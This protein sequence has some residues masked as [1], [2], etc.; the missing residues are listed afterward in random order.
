MEILKI[1]ITALTS[2]GF[3]AFIEFLIRRK[4]D[5][6]QRLEKIEKSLEKTERDNCRTQML[7]LINHYPQAH[8]EIMKIA[9]HYF[10]DLAG[11]WYMTSIFNKWLISQNLGKPE[12]FNSD[13]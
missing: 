2:S 4:D 10:R 3:F 7:I 1:V 9:L 11:D 6:S 8:E 13:N 12:W 5:T